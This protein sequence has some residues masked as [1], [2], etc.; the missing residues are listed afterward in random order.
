MKHNDDMLINKTDMIWLQWIQGVSL[1]DHIRNIEIWKAATVNSSP[2]NS[3]PDAEDTALVL[4][5]KT[6]R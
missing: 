4:R 6:E 2:D 1:I 5:C 3:T